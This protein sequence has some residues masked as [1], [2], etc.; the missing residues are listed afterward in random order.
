MEADR[1]IE[2]LDGIFHSE[3]NR[4]SSNKM[5]DDNEKPFIAMLYNV[6]FD[7]DLCDQL[8]LIIA[9]MNLV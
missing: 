3:T 4:I 6:P 8:F 1:F 2:V 7:P 9:L 5:R